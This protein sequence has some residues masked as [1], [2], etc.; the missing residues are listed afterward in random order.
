MRILLVEDDQALPR[1]SNHLRG[2][3]FRRRYGSTV[4]AAKLAPLLAEWGPCYC[5]TCIFRMA[6]GFN[7]AGRDGVPDASGIIFDRP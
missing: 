3:G 6:M 4:A 2:K 1:A 7:G 5:L